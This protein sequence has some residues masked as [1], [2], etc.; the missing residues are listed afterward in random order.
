MATIRKRGDRYHVQIRKKGQPPITKSFAKKSDALTLAKTVES[1]IERGIFLDT[2]QAQQQT[3]ADVLERYRAE[4]LP[5]LSSTALRSD[6]FRL[7]TLAEH[8]GKVTLAKLSSA[9][10]ATFLDANPF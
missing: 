10:L 7:N 1:R 4:I 8:F 3:V 2:S 5:K 9:L 6:P